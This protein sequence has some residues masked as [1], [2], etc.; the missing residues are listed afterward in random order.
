[1]LKSK[2]FVVCIDSDGCAMDTMNFKHYDFFG[3]LAAKEWNVKNEEK[4]LKIWNEVNLFSMTRGVNRFKGLYMTFEKMSE[5]DIEVK[6]LNYVKK[7]CV[8]ST[9]LSN[10]ALFEKIKKSENEDEKIELNKALEW[11]KKVNDGIK[12]CHDKD[13]PYDGVLETLKFI[14]E[15]ADIVIVSSANHDAL[16][17][18]WTK[19][20]LMDYV[21]E[22][23]SQNQGSKAEC[24]EK[25]L[26]SGYNKHNLLMVGDSPGDLDAANLNGVY[27]YP[28]LVNDEKQSW[29]E[30]KNKYID[31]FLKNDFLNVQAKLIENFKNNLKGG[32]L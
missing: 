13:K 31:I 30:L 3:P 12:N 5:I 28:I 17:S 16:I 14:K 20:G 9:K 27:F 2:N 26:L 22:I 21:D 7:W 18:E 11:S 15:F 8:E 24:I 23:M 25:V 4:F 1:M 29:E 10:D 19:H 32:N 6:K